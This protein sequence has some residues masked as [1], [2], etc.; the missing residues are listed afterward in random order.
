MPTRL[1]QRL[2]RVSVPLLAALSLLGGAGS[3]RAA[4]G[5]LTYYGGPVAHSMNVVLAIWGT[6]VRSTYTDPA[7]G[8]PA[9]FSYLAGQSGSPSDIGGV[10]A[11]YMDSSGHNSQNRLS[12]AGAV[13]LNPAVGATPPATV[14]DTDIQNELAADISSGT[15]PAP[16]GTGLSTVYVVLLPPGDDVCASGS[17]AYSG[18]G[19]CAY[20][21]SFQLSGSSTQVLYDAI[22][23]DGPGTANDGYCG[24]SS[25]DLSNQT[26]VVSH[27]LA[28]TINDPLVGEAS[29]YGPPLGWYN[30]SV[31]EVADICVGPAEQ[32][33]N[34]PWTVQALWSNLDN[35]CVAGEPAYSAPTASF[36][37]SST[38]APRQAVSF[39]ASSSSDPAQN[40]AATSYAGTSYSIASG[41][42]SYAWSWGDGSSTGAATSPTATHSF[43]NAGN[44]QVSLTVTDALGFTS[45]VT[46]EVSVGSSATTSTTTATATGTATDS[47]ATSATGTSAPSPPATSTPP[48]QSSPPAAPTP[49]SVVTGSASRLT[50]SAATVSGT[51]TPR[52]SATTYQFQFGTT[53]AYGHSS[54]SVP[55]GAGAGSVAVK[56]TL[57]G[58]RAQTT[59]H[60]RLVAMSQDGTTVGADRTFTTARAGAAAP[61]LSFTVTRPRSVRSALR[62]GLRLRFRCSARC[63]VHF[64]AMALP[65]G[66]VGRLGSVPVTVA[67]GVTHAGARRTATFTLRFSARIRRRLASR[68]SLVLLVTG[69]AVGGAQNPPA[70]VELRI[71]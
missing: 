46:R 39:D 16:A 58:L 21:S 24:A 1:P 25:D 23:D 5:P 12:Y 40:T 52:G 18:S 29:G 65:T 4:S 34:G 20:H 19:F 15:L 38:A 22:V 28:E 31:G 6:S 8:D 68:R 63:I 2:L 66:S 64:E 50:S 26:D 48:A 54:S 43:A 17:C 45:T 35:A 13:Q 70:R 55:A 30:Q 67:A 69:Y 41:I 61:R 62:R 59:Y 42:T 44:Y 11:Q 47:G 49:P 60:Y 3:A 53:A 27:E 36:L 33:L 9:F 57:S 10:L 32:A 14:Q 51:V 71:R 7:S 56:T 37:A